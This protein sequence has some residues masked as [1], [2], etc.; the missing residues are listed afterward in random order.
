MKLDPE[1]KRHRGGFVI[2]LALTT[3][4]GRDEMMIFFTFSLHLLV[5]FFF[6]VLVCGCPVRGTSLFLQAQGSNPE[7]VW[8]PG[9]VAAA[10]W[11]EGATSHWH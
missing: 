9:N 4:V 11:T 8:R 10:L 1:A 2:I 6:L 3:F 7:V 5:F